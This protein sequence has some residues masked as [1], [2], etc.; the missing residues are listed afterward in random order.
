MLSFKDF[1]ILEKSSLNELAKNKK[2]GLLRQRLN[3]LL[4]NS[5]NSEIRSKAKKALELL[6]KI[7]ASV[8][9]EDEDDDVSDEDINS[10]LDDLTK[11]LDSL[12]LSGGEGPQ[13]KIN[14]ANAQSSMKNIFNELYKT[15]QPQAKISEASNFLQRAAALSANKKTL[16][17]SELSTAWSN[18]AAGLKIVDSFPYNNENFRNSVKFLFGCLIL[19]YTLK[20][21]IFGG[22]GIKKLDDVTQDESVSREIKKFSADLTIDKSIIDNFPGYD[23]ASLFISGLNEFFEKLDEKAKSFK[24]EQKA[25]AKETSNNSTDNLNPEKTKEETSEEKS[26]SE[27]KSAEKEI[28][29]IENTKSSEVIDAAKNGER[30]SLSDSPEVFNRKVANIFGSDDTNGSLLD[31]YIRMVNEI[32]PKKA[33]EPV[34]EDIYDIVNEARLGTYLKNKLGN[35]GRVDKEKSADSIQKS[36]ETTIQD[37]EN[38]KSDFLIKAT[39]LAE[40][41]LSKTNSIRAREKAVRDLNILK[42]RYVEKLRECLVHAQRRNRLSEV[43]LMKKDAK[44]DINNLK[45]KAKAAYQNSSFGQTKAY[46]N[47]LDDKTISSFDKIWNN[48]DSAD[49]K[50]LAYAVTSGNL[51]TLYFKNSIL[52]SLDGNGRISTENLADK[53]KEV[54]AK[55]DFVI[56]D[57]VNNF[58]KK[59]RSSDWA[60]K[61]KSEIDKL[62]QEYANYVKAYNIIKPRLLDIVNGKYDNQQNNNTSDDQAT[63]DEIQAAANSP[64]P[65]AQNNQQAGTASVVTEAIQSSTAKQ[66]LLTLLNSPKDS[67][68]LNTLK[69]IIGFNGDDNLVIN[70]ILQFRR[71][72]PKI[73]QKL[74]QAKATVTTGDADGLPS[75][76]YRNAMRRKIESYI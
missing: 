12:L 73:I 68:A 33:E 2:Y 17:Y 35:I 69:Q 50:N 66:A 63:K 29:D 18:I 48:L 22:E 19:K 41:A 46:Q 7:S 76:L 44:E 62:S 56:N 28:K 11:S 8:V 21:N 55:N 34:K 52:N 25:K 61:N 40:T 1:L 13:D 58:I 6:D 24:A 5:P 10:L 65:Q 26:S 43:G 23:S 38:Y 14:D 31:K 36:L 64:Q 60:T 53:L 27:E 59:L 51:Q 42:S 37:M 9:A 71:E 3:D 72:N 39:S 57:N 45:N 16:A 67:N 49:K 75:R 32:Q 30:F 20:S 15:L 74:S 54:S 4:E 47:E 70:S